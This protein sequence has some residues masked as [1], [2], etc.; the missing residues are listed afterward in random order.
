MNAVTLLPT[1]HPDGPEGWPTIRNI[2]SAAD[3][4]PGETLFTDEELA[5][6]IA[7]LRPAF[8]AW[9]AAIVQPYIIVDFFKRLT[10]A[11]WATIKALAKDNQEIAYLWDY[12]LSLREGIECPPDGATPARAASQAAKAACAAIFGQ[13]RADQLF[14]K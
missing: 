6:H 11:E 4:R 13:E 14:A 10:I 1:G 5:A 12:L 2:G 7:S 9:Q 8:D 3:L